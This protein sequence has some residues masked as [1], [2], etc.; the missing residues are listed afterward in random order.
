MDVG[1]VS[2]AS[3]KTH[4]DTYI[5]IYIKHKTDMQASIIL[6]VEKRI[7]QMGPMIAAQLAPIFWMRSKMWALHGDALGLIRFGEL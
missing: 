3:H 7:E 2:V 6:V 1:I 4:M 5:Y